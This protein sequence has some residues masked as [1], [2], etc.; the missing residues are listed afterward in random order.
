MNSPVYLTM[1]LVFAASAGVF[2][3]FPSLEVNWP[4][5]GG[6]QMSRLGRWLNVAFFLVM[7]AMWFAKDHTGL[8]VVI[9]NVAGI[10]LVGMVPAYVHDRRACRSPPVKP[11]AEG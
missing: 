9:L 11:E 6:V 8:R 2:A 5:S 3:V 10:I 7:S 4:M 1:M